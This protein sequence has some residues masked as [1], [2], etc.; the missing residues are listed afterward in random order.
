MEM[1]DVGDRHKREV[2]NVSRAQ[3]GARGHFEELEG[4]R[5]KAGEIGATAFV[6]KPN[7]V[8][9]MERVAREIE[10]GKVSGEAWREERSHAKGKDPI[11]KKQAA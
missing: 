2:I 11:E 10:K 4:K 7:E 5:R 1:R 3:K 9:E 8:D 6:L